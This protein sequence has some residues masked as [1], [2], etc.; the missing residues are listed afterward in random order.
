M[1]SSKRLILKKAEGKFGQKPEERTISELIKHG[2]VNI[3]KPSGPTS[4]QVADYVKKILQIKKAGHSGT[5]DPKVTG[6][7]PIA[8]GKATRIT[9]F[10][11]T[12]PKEYIGIMR[13][14]KDISINEIK[15]AIKEK[16]KGKI[17]QKPP[18]KSRVKREEREREVKKFLNLHPGLLS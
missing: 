7:Q 9:H 5:L 11:L 16:F 2:V 18:V 8:L 13:I 17:L 14:H 1:N 6:V 12:A 3:D 10:L 4:H 15:K